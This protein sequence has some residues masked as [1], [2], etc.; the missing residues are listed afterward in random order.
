MFGCTA[1][2][3]LTIP[4]PSADQDTCDARQFSSVIGQNVTVLEQVLIMRQIRIIRSG[5][6]VTLDFVP[7]RLNVNLGVAERIQSL[8]CG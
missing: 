6:M 2:P 1:A 5:Q 8:T 4:L 7:E 3:P